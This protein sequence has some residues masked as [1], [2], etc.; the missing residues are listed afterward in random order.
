MKK[1]WEDKIVQIYDSCCGGREAVHSMVISLRMMRWARRRAQLG[2]K[3][4]GVAMHACVVAILLI[5]FS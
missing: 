4:L 1:H 3:G 5:P 2:W